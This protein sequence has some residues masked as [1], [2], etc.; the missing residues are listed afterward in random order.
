MT[1]FQGRSSRRGQAISLSLALREGMDKKEGG[2]SLYVGGKQWTSTFAKYYI[3]QLTRYIAFGPDLSVPISIPK[4][5]NQSW[6][7]LLTASLIIR[8]YPARRDSGRQFLGM[9]KSAQKSEA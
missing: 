9:G 3:R 6:R 4:N 5:F 8:R 7:K 2:K 1:G